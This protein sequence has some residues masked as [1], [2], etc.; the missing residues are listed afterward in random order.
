ME[1]IDRFYEL[2]NKFNPVKVYQEYKEIR[3]EARQR[4]A[5]RLREH[6]GNKVRPAYLNPKLLE[7]MDE[8][9]EEFR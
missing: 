5:D 9:F 2:L 8:G 1:I 4:L 6:M 7:L 3:D